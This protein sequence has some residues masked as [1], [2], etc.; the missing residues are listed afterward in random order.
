M[1][2][3]PKPTRLKILEGVHKSKIHRNEP[4][5]IQPKRV[6]PAPS[7]LNNIGKR[8]WK[9]IAK[10]LHG[11]GLLTNLDKTAL[12]GYCQC[13]V[14]YIDAT[15]KIQEQG[16]LVKAQ[17]GFP[18]QSPYVSIA[19]KAMVEMRKWLLE[20]GMTPSSRSKITIQ[21]DKQYGHGRGIL[22]YIDDGSSLL[23]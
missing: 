16:V 19:N 8:E 13:Y 15:K 9:R 5:P 20:F 10:E 7:Y 17:S 3:R 4:K 22:K 23:T 21:P 6:P 12:A 2:P 18:M 11:L 14:M 1:A